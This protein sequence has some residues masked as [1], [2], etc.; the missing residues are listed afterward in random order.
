MPRAG[1]TRDHRPE[2]LTLPPAALDGHAPLAARLRPRTLEEFVGQAHLVGDNGALRRLVERG[3][4]GSMVLW[5][6]PGSGEATLPR[7]PP[8]AT[9]PTAQT[10]RGGPRSCRRSRTARSRS[11]A[12]RRRTRTSRSTRRS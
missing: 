2:A 7:P 6:P 10:G 5:G 9:I 8:P 12:P 1:P 4:L 11:S 3:H